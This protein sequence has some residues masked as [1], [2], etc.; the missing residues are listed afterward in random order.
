MPAAWFINPIVQERGTNMPLCETFL[1]G[2][3]RMRYL[4]SSAI[5]P[6][7]GMT[8]CL[9]YVTTREADF[10]DLEA[11]PGVIKVFDEVMDDEPDGSGPTHNHEKAWLRGKHQTNIATLNTR[12]GLVGEGGSGISIDSSRKEILTILGKAACNHDARDVNFNPEAWY[13]GHR[14]S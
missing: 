4:H 3:G 10:A 7:R 2:N 8:W 9:S 13:T 12:L 5:Y 11:E 6:E 14:A 1:D